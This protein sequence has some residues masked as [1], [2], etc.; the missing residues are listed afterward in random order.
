MISSVVSVRQPAFDLLVI[1]WLIVLREQ[2]GL[3]N[4]FNMFNYCS[5]LSAA[6]FASQQL[7]KCNLADWLDDGWLQFRDTRVE[8]LLAAL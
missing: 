5:L 3:M 7:Q 2:C 4:A 6:P 8:T 1:A